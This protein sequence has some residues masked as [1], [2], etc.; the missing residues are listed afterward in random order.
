MIQSDFAT[1]L[2]YLDP[3]MWETLQE[4]FSREI[5]PGTIQDI[6]DGEEYSKF[7]GPGG[8]L[9]SH[10]PAN[11]S[12]LINTDGVQLFRSSVTSSMWPIWLVINE[13]PASVR[14]M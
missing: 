11:V 10:H 5:I 4:R 3:K 8:F 13:L 9:S 14:Y 2:L 1:T 6:Y 12:L 7:T